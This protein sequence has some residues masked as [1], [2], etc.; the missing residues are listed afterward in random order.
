M[1][2][3]GYNNTFDGGLT[4]AGGRTETTIRA[5]TGSGITLGSVAADRNNL[6]AGSIALSGNNTL[7]QILTSAANQSVNLASGTLAITNGAQV[8]I[9]KNATTHTGGAFNLSGGTLDGGAGASGTLRLSGLNF[10]ITGGSITNAPNLYLDSGT[11]ATAT[12]VQNIGGSGAINGLGDITKEGPGSLKIADTITSLSADNLFFRSGTLDLGAG[13]D[14]TLGGTLQLGVTSTG[15][16]TQSVLLGKDGQ[17][18]ADIEVL[19]GYTDLL[20]NNYYNVAT[21]GMGGFD[22]TLGNITVGNLAALRLDMGAP[23]S[24]A[25]VNTLTLT[26]N[27][28]GVIN[29]L[30]WEGNPWVG[31]AP[32][33]NGNAVR[34]DIILL[35]GGVNP[36]DVWVYGFEKGVV[37]TGNLNEYRPVT[38]ISSTFNYANQSNYFD[39]RNWNGG[40]NIAGMEVADHAGATLVIPSASSLGLS[41][42]GNRTINLDGRTI[43]LG[44]FRDSFGKNGDSPVAL[45]SGT[46]I[47]D[48]GIAGQPAVWSQPVSG[49]SS[50]YATS[51][52]FSDLSVSSA[53]YSYFSG[54]ISGSGGLI[55]NDNGS[56]GAGNIMI[57]S[58]A[59]T[60]TGGVT[61][62]PGSA[63]WIYPEGSYT[64]GSTPLG[65]GTL[66]VNG[67]AAISGRR[68]T[69]LGDAIRTITNPL[70]LNGNITASHLTFAYGGDIELTG[71]RTI[72]VNAAPQNNPGVNSV[73]FSATT[74]LTG[75]GALVKTGTYALQ[76]QSGSNTFSGGL[77]VNGGRV[78]LSARAGGL[79]IGGS[80]PGQNYL[81]SGSLTIN[82]SASYVIASLAAGSTSEIRGLVTVSNYGTLMLIGPDST[83]LLQNTGTIDGGTDAA[84]GTFRMDSGTF[85]NNGIA[86]AR[87]PNLMFYGSGTTWFTGSAVSGIGTLTRGEPGTAYL[88]TTVSGNALSISAGQLVLN[89]SGNS[90]N[91]VGLSGGVLRTG[92]ATNNSLGALYLQ[93]NAGIY[94]E[95][96]SVLTFSR[97]GGTS[98]TQWTASQQLNLANDDGKWN[99]DGHS[100]ETNNYIFIS[101][102]AAIIS[103]SY[104]AQLS[105]IAFTGYAP[106]ATFLKLDTSGT[107]YLA[108]N[109]VQI[110]EWSGHPSAGYTGTAWNVGDNWINGVPDAAGDYAA[111]REVDQELSGKTITVE[112]DFALGALEIA[113]TVA[114]TLGGGTLAFDNNSGTAALKLLSTTSPTINSALQLN[115]GLRFE[116]N[117]AANVVLNGKI[118]G[119]GGIIYSAGNPSYARYLRFA[120]DAAT[121]DF[122][123]GFRWIGS[124]A[125]AP[126]IATTGNAPRIVITG[127]GSYFGTGTL[128]IGDGT[129]GVWYNL[130]PDAASVTRVVDVGA[131]EIAGNLFFGQPAAGSYS[132]L[133]LHSTT[134]T[135]FITTGTWTLAG[136]GGNGGSNAGASTLVLDMA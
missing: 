95:T 48:S 30:N 45:S 114:F 50:I 89:R 111:I 19:A 25:D 105:R 16:L 60:F 46:V 4:L 90:F 123:G 113:N 62:N 53:Q 34:D 40:T 49:F 80:A 41:T 78:N 106:G 12:T 24:G 71:T 118:S 23:G 69:G 101:D 5:D 64:S 47:W 134:G 94:M 115:D 88:D 1:R 132:T 54:I 21:L 112:G 125:T 39:Y 67:N 117:S 66:T 44:A 8:N 10:N 28:A 129:A 124:T 116:N 36:D 86:F 133:T 82:N 102:T 135:G 13:A 79:V 15:A 128:A 32:L 130:Q 33:V 85:V 55:I 120:G 122:S 6:G 7:L 57:S 98:A 100:T 68:A 9:I 61:L 99:R 84:K 76:L 109:S 127:S 83:T 11:G 14:L 3:T 63:L 97:L 73:A 75:A 37:P 103:G 26:G 38:F 22:Q 87:T 20:S 77:T 17:L 119:D 42:S 136:S 27:N 59:N 35:T 31:G 96:D 18:T 43:T 81:G 121:N 2:L 91:T 58:M 110:K 126:S 107:Y 108:P 93:G 92:T 131:L 70:V 52:L 29:I 65:T 56:G 51:V 72:T 74:N 104:A